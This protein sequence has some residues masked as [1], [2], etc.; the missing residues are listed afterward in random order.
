MQTSLFLVALVHLAIIVALAVLLTQ[1]CV[2]GYAHP[3]QR[4]TTEK[5]GSVSLPVVTICPDQPSPAK[6]PRAPTCLF[7]LTQVAI[8]Y[9]SACTAHREHILCTA[10]TLPTPTHL[11]PHAGPQP[12]AAAC[13]HPARRHQDPHAHRPRV[14]VLVLRVQCRPL[15]TLAGHGHIAGARRT[16]VIEATTLRATAAA[17]YNRGCNPMYPI[18]A[19][20]RSQPVWLWLRVRAQPGRLH[21]RRGARRAA[22]RPAAVG[23]AVPA[24]EHH[25][26]ADRA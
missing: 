23:A 3:G 20:R 4:L 14:R 5:P 1:R 24:G 12:A 21:G 17:Q 15:L 25:P 19:L 13:Q 26:P 6:L 18:A 22:H 9:P 8:P 10:V 11:H 16:N 7:S 2:D